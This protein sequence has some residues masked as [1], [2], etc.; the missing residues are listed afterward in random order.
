[1]T[2]FKVERLGKRCA[3]SF[4][5]AG[6]MQVGDDMRMTATF[7]G[8][9]TGVEQGDQGGCAC[10]CCQFRQFVMGYFVVNGVAQPG[11]TLAYGNKLSKSVYR[12]DGPEPYGHRDLPGTAGDR[13]L[14]S[15]SDGCE[16]KGED[17]TGVDVPLSA[18]DGTSWYYEHYFRSVIIDTC[19]GSVEMVWEWDSSCYGIIGTVA[20]RPYDEIGGPKD[21]RVRKP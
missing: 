2:D 16:Y 4:R 3:T 1:M 12:E 17:F 8:G 11:R 13:Y 21:P 5:K 7:S 6:L 10:Y 20:A 9:E 18:A 14:T 15:Q 19:T